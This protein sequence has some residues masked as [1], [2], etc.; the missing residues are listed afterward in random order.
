MALSALKLAKDLI[1]CPS[2]TPVDA[3]AQ[4]L[5]ARELEKLGFQC[6]HLEFNGVPNLFA[7]LGTQSPHLCFAGHT[8]VV[9]PG[10]ESAWTHGP[11]KPTEENGKLIGRGACDMKG[12]VAAFPAA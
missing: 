3:G 9:P 5:L 2:V 6:H 4:Q 7:R 11:F 1:S 8:D 12:A 10:P